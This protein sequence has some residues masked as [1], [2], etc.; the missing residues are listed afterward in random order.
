LGGFIPAE[1]ISLS[2]VAHQRIKPDAFYLISMMEII[3]LSPMTIDFIV[4]S[5]TFAA[6]LTA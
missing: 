1:N 3:Y 6:A 4:G 2:V 5:G